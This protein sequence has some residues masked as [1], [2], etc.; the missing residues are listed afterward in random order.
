MI[1][2]RAATVAAR[3][4]PPSCNRMIGCSWPNP[5]SA[6]DAIVEVFRDSDPDRDCTSQSRGSTDHSTTR[7][8]YA[9]AARGT[10][11][12]RY[13]PGGRKKHGR[14][15]VTRDTTAEVRDICRRR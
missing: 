11:P 8:R 12:G 3:A 2:G 6:R 15:P 4:P 5:A 9:A 1:R 14:S 13:P 7:S 10:D